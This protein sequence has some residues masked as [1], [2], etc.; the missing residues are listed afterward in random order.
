[1]YQI[2]RHIAQLLA[3]A[4]EAAQARG[5]LPPVALPEIVI[6]RPQNREHGDF[7]SNLALRLAR[8]AR[9]NPLAIA[10]ALA[11]AMPADADIES[12]AVAAPGF[13][14]FRLPPEWLLR[15]VDAILAAG[16]AYGDVDLGGGQRVQVEFVSANP[17]GPLHVGHGRGAV[18]GSALA[19]ALE[20]AGYAVTREY[21]LNDT[22]NQIDSFRRSLYARYLQSL[23]QPAEMPPDGYYGQYL[24]E[25]AADI[26]AAAGARLAGL[27]ADEATAEVERLGLERMTAAIRQDLADLGV[28]FD[29]WFSE[30]SL[31][32]GGAYD[33]VM[34]RLRDGGHL[35]Q[36]EGALWF[37]TTALGEDKD[38]VIVRST[39]APT[40]FA[41]D[42]AYHYDKFVRRRFDRVIDVWGAD[43]LGHVSRV[44]AAVEVLG[45]NPDRLEVIVSQL[46]TLRRGPEI[47]R[48]SKRS[49]DIVTLREVLDEV[50]ADACR[51][52][53]LSRSASSQMD[54]DL[55]LA[56]QQ[57]ADNP[58][59]YI[60]YGHARIASILRYAAD[61]GATDADANPSLLT[62]PAELALIHQMT[63]LPEVVETVAKALEPHHLAYYALELATAFHDFYERCRVVGDDA[64]LTAARLRLVAAAKLTTGRTLALMG[65]TAPEQM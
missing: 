26:G 16:T 54:F 56:K 49:G 55:E 28:V 38:N 64:A 24:I 34:A 47:V 40:Y 43:H 42:I 9:M 11:E 48:L 36:K 17:T 20:A 25:L 7:A 2:K 63:L 22:G 6:E 15:Q 13:I 51:F 3:E 31:Y 46:V 50:G 35:V 21:Y 19:N 18:L 61:R 62:S 52:F 60:Q 53:F 23:G 8:A 65:M 1:M 58:V 45:I 57:S 44:K 29:T 12:V 14:N 39:G 5:T 30:T 4:A 10:N 27:P 37:A 41:S 32:S 33:D 59:Y